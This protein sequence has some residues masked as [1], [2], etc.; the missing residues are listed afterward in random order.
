MLMMYDVTLIMGTAYLIK[1]P[2]LDH[3]TERD[4]CTVSKTPHFFVVTIDI[5]L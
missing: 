1:L 5:G 4:S 2:L 3:F